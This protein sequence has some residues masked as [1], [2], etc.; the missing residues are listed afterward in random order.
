MDEVKD[1]VPK[2]TSALVAE[3]ASQK[4][5]AP[6]DANR[7]SA[8]PR[9]IKAY[10]WKSLLHFANAAEERAFDEFVAKDCV[11]SKEDIVK[12]YKRFCALDTNKNGL[13]DAQEI[14][15]IEQLHENPL[16]SRLVAIFD[17]DGSGSLDFIE[18]LTALAIFS[19]KGTADAKVR[20]MFD[21]FDADGDGFITNDELFAT[22]DLMTGDDFDKKSLQQITDKTML[23]VCGDAD[24][25]I[26]FEQYR[27]FL[28]ANNQ[29]L[30]AKL[31]M[32]V[33]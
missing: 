31:T 32:H 4:A 6:E 28:T 3:A 13:I 17:R 5:A 20:V 9:L 15:S 16:V 21:V 27:N 1:P 25:A 30:I 7:A 10:N 2:K 11:L 26:S 33:F 12:L 14:S 19:A 24:G 18:Y 22:L 23:K 29:D 8:S